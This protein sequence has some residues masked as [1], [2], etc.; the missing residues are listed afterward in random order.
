MGRRTSWITVAVGLFAACSGE[1]GAGSRNLDGGFDASSR[2]AGN[3]VDL[4]H[5]GVPDGA[6]ID[7]N[8]DG[9]IDGYDTDGDGLIDVVV[10]GGA[11]NADASVPNYPAPDPFMCGDAV[12]ACSNGLDDDGDGLIDLAD[13]ECIASWDNDESSFATGIPGDNRDDACQDCF[14][15]G[16]SGSGDDGCRL[17]TSCLSEGNA[18]SGRGNCNSCE[19]T[20]QCRNFCQAYTPNGCD[21]FGCCGVHLDDGTTVNVLIGANCQ[22]DGNDVTGCQTCVPNKSCINECGRCELCPGKEPK[23]LPPDCFSTNPPSP[24]PPAD[25]G[26]SEPPPPPYTCDNGAVACG[27]GLPACPEDYACQFGCCV[28][29]PIILF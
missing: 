20:D 11:A 15:D 22:I 7:T 10:P 23:D 26:T 8:G 29:T 25:G 12:C 5:D 9:I 28:L 13:P 27:S 24:P 2:D 1:G 21:C 6:P 16:N 3:W 4:N 19:Q 14:F 17:P 18:S